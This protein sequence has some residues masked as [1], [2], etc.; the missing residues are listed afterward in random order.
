[1]KAKMAWRRQTLML[2]LE[3]KETMGLDRSMSSTTAEELVYLQV[4]LVGLIK[5]QAWVEH[6]R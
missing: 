4:V 3:L 6:S 1:M 5:A 2:R